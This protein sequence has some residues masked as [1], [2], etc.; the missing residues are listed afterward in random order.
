MLIKN[1]SSVIPTYGVYIQRYLT[2]LNLLDKKK[3][4]ILDIGCGDGGI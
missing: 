2:A 3:P 4:L 1:L